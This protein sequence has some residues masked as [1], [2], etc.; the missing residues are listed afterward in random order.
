M[1][2][3]LRSE[4][5]RITSRR[6]GRIMAIVILAITVLAFARIAQVNSPLSDAQRQQI[7]AIREQCEQAERSRGNLEPADYC[8]DVTGGRG[9][10]SAREMLGGGVQ[11]VAGIFPL[12]ALI[13]CASYV[14]ADWNHGTMQALLFWEPRRAR[15]LLAKAAA[16]AIT[17]FVA[18]MAFQLLVYLLTYLVA[19]TR[20][21]TEGV[22]GG[23]HMSNLLTMLR[24]G[25]AA[26]VMGLMA[27]AVAG[28][29]RYT[30]AAI[31]GI[32]GYLLIVESLIRG[33]RPGWER[34]LFN[35]NMGAVLNKSVEVANASGERFGSFSGPDGQVMATGS[36]QLG[37]VRGA[38]TLCVYLAVF[39]GGF[40]YT[41]TRRDV[42]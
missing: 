4:L 23:L 35:V 11:V 17:V 36:Y 25:F 34:F 9:E 19:A 14:G 22:T 3:L 16:V 27:Y 30:I 31:G 5:R 1:T 29:A 32:L 12:L 2:G 7:T 37:G 10:F 40:Y 8:Q 13:L 20:G 28:L 18:M 21:T 42:T 6:M 24:G 26:V 33:L 41:F 38:I 15:V 39:L